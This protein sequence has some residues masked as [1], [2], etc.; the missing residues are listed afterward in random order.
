MGIATASAALFYSLGLP[1][2][3]NP[4]ANQSSAL[5]VWGG[6]SSVGS[7]AVQL[8]R[9]LG[10]TVFTTASPNN[11]DYLKS[12]GASEVF[13]YHTSTVV[14]DL[15]EAAKKAGKPIR[16][17]VDAVSETATLQASVESA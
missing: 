8:G 13:D 9:L 7:N 15:L 12:L 1:L 3:S 16:L 10:F 4:P 5:L 17:A 6:A 2:P 14:D 11:H